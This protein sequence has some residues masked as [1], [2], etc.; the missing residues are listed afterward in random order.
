MTLPTSS[1]P[2]LP[3]D[4]NPLVE[5]AFSLLRRGE[6]V[7]AA[8]TIESAKTMT[9][10][11]PRVHLIQGRICGARQD[12]PGMLL[13]S[14]RV[15]AAMPDHP[16]SIFAKVHALYSM[17]RPDE[18]IATIDATR[19]EGDPNLRHNL[20]GLRAKSLSRDGDPEELQR[21]IDQLIE[22]EG[23]SPRL[24]L[25][26][27]ALHRRLAEDD[28]ATTMCR[29]LL[30]RADVPP[31][32]RVEAGFELARLL[33]QSGEYA[34]AFEAARE[35]NQLGAGHFDREAFKRS[36]KEIQ[37]FFSKDRFA[38]GSTIAR[39]TL[40]T[41]DRPVFIVG[42][43]RSG[44]SLLEQIIAAHP[45]ADGVGERP[46]PFLIAEDLSHLFRTPF[47]KWLDQAGPEVLDRA[48]ERY[49]CMLD[50][51][52][53][54]SRRVTNKALGL[55]A[56]VGLMATILPESK[57]LW[58]RRSHPD[59][60]LSIWLHQIQLPWAWKLEDIDL[61][62]EI[63]DQAHDHWIETLPDRV[64]SISYEGLIQS[65]VTETERILHFLDLPPA[66]ECLD[67]HRSERTV[68]TPSAAQVRRPLHG[69]AI[70]RSARYREFL[71]G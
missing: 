9:P 66:Q 24:V 14:E 39:S 12:A 67:F 30:A 28:L 7:K 52:G 1:A 68:M 21:H 3:S 42:M 44:T 34:S 64:C 54:R 40:A 29:D 57:F 26:Q 38:Q 13:A 22:T 16:E 37:E 70:G 46:D 33:D 20:L 8:A 45:E 51:M 56:M 60:R 19:T 36:A 4:P 5:E 27:V 25:M 6:I 71:K 58:I 65:Q 69:K 10:D 48:A 53:G 50:T 61:A 32:D 47:P 59:N 63:H 18:A 35:A 62:R 15:L 55:D 23:N 49:S 31:R 17:G 41:T 2:G 43:P 11:D